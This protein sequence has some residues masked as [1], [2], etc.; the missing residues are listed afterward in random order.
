LKTLLSQDDPESLEVLTNHA[1]MLR[2]AL[3]KDFGSFATAVKAFDF[4]VALGLVTSIN[5]DGGLN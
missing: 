2:Q 5:L 1:P 4:D 3:G